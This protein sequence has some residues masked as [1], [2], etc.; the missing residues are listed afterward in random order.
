[1][2]ERKA[3][4][5]GA[6]I[7]AIALF[8]ALV[9]FTAMIP[10]SFYT[11]G[12]GFTSLGMAAFAPVAGMVL[13][14]Y[15]GFIACYVGGIIGMF[16]SP[17]AYPLGLIDAYLS[18]A[19]LGLSW[20]FASCMDKR[21]CKMIYIPWVLGQDAIALIVPFIWPGPPY[22]SPMTEFMG[23]PG[24][25]VHFV[26]RYM[27]WIFLAVFL[28]FGVTGK[29]VEWCR[30]ED[31]KKLIL[32]FLFLNIYAR[33]GWTPIWGWPYGEYIHSP[34]ETGLLSAFGPLWPL[35]QWSTWSQVLIAT[36]LG[37]AIVIG[38]RKTGYLKVPRSLV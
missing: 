8:A 30:S 24:I 12:G 36:F 35:G 14:P 34:W 10:I 31:K 18:G 1:M 33:Y 19:C 23:M 21:E 4:L 5:F 37:S 9:G 26:R 20:G 2:A 38:L 25:V 16:L 29:A 13:G 11:T 7:A 6:P 15:A 32:G 17:G 3:V 22:Y 28:I 27:S